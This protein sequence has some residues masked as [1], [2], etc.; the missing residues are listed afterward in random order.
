MQLTAGAG[1]TRREEVPGGW[2]VEEWGASGEA[3]PGTTCRGSGLRQS[4][5]G[6]QEV[7]Q[8][9]DVSCGGGGEGTPIK[10]SNKEGRP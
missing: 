9:L 10:V 2:R 1:E 5:L 4:Y 6:C 3:A 7:F 8:M